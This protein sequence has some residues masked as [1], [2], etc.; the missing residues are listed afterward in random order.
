[1]IKVFPPALQ[2]RRTPPSILRKLGPE[3]KLFEVVLLS[4]YVSR[5]KKWRREFWSCLWCELQKKDEI[6]NEYS[7]ATLLKQIKELICYYFLCYLERLERVHM[8]LFGE[9][10]KFWL[11]LHNNCLWEILFS[12]T[13]MHSSRMRTARLLIVS[14]ETA[15]PQRGLHLAVSVQPQGG[16]CLPNPGGVCI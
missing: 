16:G 12:I 9:R 6:L 5:C 11:T 2:R 14:G 3:G 1:M 13:S 7:Q 10:R 8:D 15:Q 4:E